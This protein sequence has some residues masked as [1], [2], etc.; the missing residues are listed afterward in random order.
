MNGKTIRVAVTGANGQLGQELRAMQHLHPSFEFH[1]FSKAEWDI[2][3][4]SVN[5]VLMKG[6]KPDV[7]INAAAY[8]NVEKAEEDVENAMAANA[9][10]P[11]F[12]AAACKEQGGLLIHISTDYVFDGKKKKPYTEEDDVHP[13]N[14]Y[15]KS[16]L[17]GERA[18]DAKCHRYFILRTSWL[19]SS[20]GHNFYKTMLRLAREKG[21]LSVVNDQYASPTYA[22]FLAADIAQLIHLRVIEQ[23]NI[24]YGIYHYTQSGVA[25]WY[26]FAREIMRVNNLDIPVAATDSQRFPTKAVRPEYSKLSTALWE[27]NTTI[28][29]KTWQEGV[30]IIATKSL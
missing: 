2:A 19:Y 16:K 7:V 22:A 8:T 25:S 1:F 28:P 23:R 6:L 26:D 20:F 21:E 30:R 15:G 11:G 13:L 18:I 24:P 4:E 17:A 27:K 5:T 3:V 29:V 9:F 10:G 14:Q 12:L